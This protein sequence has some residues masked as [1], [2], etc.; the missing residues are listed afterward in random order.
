MS[1][2]LDDRLRPHLSALV[3]GE[4]EPLEAIAVQRHLRQHADL[5]AEQQ[6]LEQLKLAV[7]LAGQ[8]DKPDPA[9]RT[10]LV[11]GVRAA[12]AERRHRQNARRWGLGL[13]AAGALAALVLA[14]LPPRGTTPS[15][16]ALAEHAPVAAPTARVTAPIDFE[17]T[18]ALDRLVAVH[19]GHVSPMALRDLTLAGA[20]VT[21]ESLP[22]GLLDPSDGR[23]PIVQA[24]YADCSPRPTGAT[25][26]VLRL[27]R[28]DLPPAV[29]A[30]LETAGVYTDVIDGVEVRLSENG[31]KLFIL[32]NDAPSASVSPI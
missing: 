24:S 23:A 25:W 8:R 12:A 27:D 31:D 29:D 18:H 13:V 11:A 28:V 22:D 6:S 32:L 16:G 21:L 15:A 20:L 19:R 14:V 3:D 4:L 30:A 1:K 17:A 26:A 10:R 7:H 9:L 2:T 5:A